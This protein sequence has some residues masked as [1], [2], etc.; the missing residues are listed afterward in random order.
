MLKTQTYSLPVASAERILLDEPVGVFAS[1]S[2]SLKSCA[3]GSGIVMAAQL[4][5]RWMLIKASECLLHYV[6]SMT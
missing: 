6:C 3:I 1:S 2:A 5:A 4:L